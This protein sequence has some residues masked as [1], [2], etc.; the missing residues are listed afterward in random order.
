MN[1]TKRQVLAG[2]G[3]L[4]AAGG[5]SAFWLLSEPQYNMP[6]YANDGLAIDGT[7]A[8]AYF[9]QNKPIEG[10]S[11]HELDWNGAKWRFASAENLELFKADPEKY[12]PAYGGYCA[13]AVAEK[14]QL[15]STQ[16]QNWAIVDDRLFLNYND[17]IQERWNADIA[18]F[19]EA[20]DR[21]WPDIVKGFATS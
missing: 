18:R 14:K 19:I 10:S 16:P 1:F 13:W 12:A 2:T 7:D 3:F 4:V 11:A 9:T 8:V 20:G 21:N 6:V 5:A 15:F 17:G